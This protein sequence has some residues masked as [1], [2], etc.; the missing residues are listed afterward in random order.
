MKPSEFY[1]KYW[2]I[3]NADGSLSNPKPPTSQER[4]F[5]D[6]PDNAYLEY[7]KTRSGQ[8]KV[9]LKTVEKMYNQLPEFIKQ[10]RNKP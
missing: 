6:N 5:M 2:K 1:E 9:G 7:F 8:R 10:G 4:E 3:V